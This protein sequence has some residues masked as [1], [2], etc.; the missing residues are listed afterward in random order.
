[1]NSMKISLI[2]DGYNVNEKADEFDPTN[3]R[4]NYLE[5]NPPILKKKKLNFNGFTIY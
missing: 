1:M 3:M 4:Q 2:S 5:G